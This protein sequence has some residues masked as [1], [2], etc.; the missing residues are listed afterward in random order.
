M[1]SGHAEVPAHVPCLI[2]RRSCT[3]AQHPACQCDGTWQCVN[4]PGT[5][6]VIDTD[7]TGFQLTSAVNGVRFDLSG[8]GISIQ[9]SWT[10]A[11]SKNGWLALPAE[12]GSIT[13]GKQLFGNFT[14]Q[15]PS[16]Q[17]NGFL[18]LAVYDQPDHGGNGDGVIDWHDAVWPKLRIWIDSN[19]NGIAEPKELY[20][21]PSLGIYSLALQYVNSPLKDQ[22]GNQFMFKGKVNPEGQPKTDDVDRVMYD[23]M[24]TGVSHTAQSK[25]VDCPQPGGSPTAVRDFLRDRLQ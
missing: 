24:L 5:P 18:A 3:A 1:G 2:S 14:P 13:S 25:S 21:L 15:P 9:I 12:D 4:N 6:I 20:T 7:G 23:V 8:N 10:A 16:D 17:P 19:H 11:S 22:Y